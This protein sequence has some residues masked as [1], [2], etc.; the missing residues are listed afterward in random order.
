MQEM[1]HLIVGDI[2]FE[3]VDAAARTA[4]EV[5]SARIDEFVALPDGSTTADAELVDIRV[6]A[7]GTIYPSA[8]DAVRSQFLKASGGKLKNQVKEALLACF[9]KV[10]WIDQSGQA[11]YEA[12]YEAL[13][14][15][16]V[17]ALTAVFNQGTH[18]IYDTD[19]LNDLRSY[20]V[21]TAYYDDGTEEIVTSYTLSGT[22]EE[23]TSVIT[24]A[25]SGM[26]TTFTVNVT[27]MPTIT[28]IEAVYTQSGTVYDT[29]T[30]ESLKDDLV[31]TA[32]LEDE[33]E[34]IVPSTDYTLSG[35]L[36][37]GVSVITVSYLGFTATFNVTVTEIIDYTL[38][39]LD[40][41]TWYDGYVYDNDSG[42][43]KAAS[44]E[45]CTEKFT[46]QNCMYMFA[47]SDST[48][49]RYTAIFA[50]DNDGNYLG[51][52]EGVIGLLS[53]KKNYTYAVK[54]YNTTTFDPSTITLLPKNNSATAS[55]AFSIK[56]SDYI[57]NI[58][59][60]SRFEFNVASVM[61]AA[62]ITASNIA[63]KINTCNY[64]AVLAMAGTS[65]PF[66]K[67]TFRFWFYNINTMMFKIEGISTVADAEAWITAND[68]I[69]KFND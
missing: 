66:A 4:S 41:I 55:A 19:S 39:P 54:T 44:G 60:S 59:G 38:N 32:I 20:L 14:D 40:G 21:V 65:E 30:L 11:L 36:E 42:I 12:L 48:N 22:L 37:R 26:T 43:I 67:R 13:Y 6:G 34:M 68:P 47:N 24:V 16:N 51:K 29:D 63:D 33:S 10:A 18:I 61:S 57:G 62:G 8:G 28:S 52:Y 50:W 58:S 49:N 35:T 5:N 1:K 69:I 53:L 64:L 31:V 15:A 45:H 23:G 3:V 25:Y 27:E 9:Q 56:L 46:A 7:D 2:E 17:F